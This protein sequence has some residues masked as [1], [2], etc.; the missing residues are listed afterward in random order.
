MSRKSKI[1]PALKVQLVERYLNG[2]ISIMAL[3][4][5]NIRRLLVVP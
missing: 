5:Y 4:R 2:E 3:Y 1:D